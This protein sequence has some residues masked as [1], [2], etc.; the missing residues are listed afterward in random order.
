MSKKIGHS[1]D[2]FNSSPTSN[3]MSG[4]FCGLPL[5][6]ELIDVPYLL[7]LTSPSCR[8]FASVFVLFIYF[9][10][11]PWLQIK[12]PVCDHKMSEVNWTNIISI[13]KTDITQASLH[14]EGHSLLR[15]RW[16]QSG[17]HSVEIKQDQEISEA[18]KEVFWC[19]YWHQLTRAYEGYQME[20]GMLTWA[21]SIRVFCL[22]DMSRKKQR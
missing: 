13:P 22:L 11:C 18:K 21:T 9:C 10:F 19:T 7:H 12:S 8:S 3:V 2:I 15:T 14:S 17:E 5:N 16:H 20:R 6:L 1:L 4:S